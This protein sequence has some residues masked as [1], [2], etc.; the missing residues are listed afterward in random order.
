MKLLIAVP[1]GGNASKP[2][3]ESLESL[4]LPPEVSAVENS[5][6]LGNFVPAQRELLARRAMEKGADVMLMIDDD[7]VLPAATIAKLLAALTADERVGLVGA[8]YYTRDGIRPMVADGW[9]ARNTTKSWI[10]AFRQGRVDDVSAVGLGCALIRV[11]ALRA[12]RPPIFAGQVYIEEAAGRV[13]I[14]N[15]DF[16]LCER[17]GKLGYSVKLHAGVRCGHYDRASGLTLPLIW[18]SDTVT[19]RARMMVV[20]PG[21][22]YSLV[23]H[24]PD[25]GTVRERHEM[26]SLEYLFVD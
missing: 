2:F 20:E 4:E 18:E 21:P 8:L 5:T 19:D 17:L 14:C 3:L 23:P 9:E 10:P 22:R 26:A 12:M 25:L 15:E 6:V 24:T 1:S 16:V 7:M 11:D 13:R